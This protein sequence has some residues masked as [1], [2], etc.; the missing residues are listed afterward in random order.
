[1]IT[2]TVTGILSCAHEPINADIFGGQVHGHSYEVTAEF[3]NDAG[4]D[5]RIFKVSF[6]TLLATLDHR[7]LPSELATAEAIARYF[8]VLNKCVF[9]EVR[10]PL[11]RL[12][13]RWRDDRFS[14]RAV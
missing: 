11:E 1:M 12:G 5:V 13:A 10:R 7:L 9:V 8:G 3:A 2:S 14:H 6:D 4:A